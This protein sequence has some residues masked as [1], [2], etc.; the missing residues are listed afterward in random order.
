MSSYVHVFLRVDTDTFIQ[1]ACDSRSS[2]LYYYLSGY[3]P[4]GQIMY[5]SAEHIASVKE[6]IEEDL[7]DYYKDID[8]YQARIKDIGTWA[9]SVEDKLEAVH[10]LSIRTLELEQE[11]DE[12]KA[13]QIRLSVFEDMIDLDYYDEDAPMRQ[14]WIGIECGSVVSVNDITETL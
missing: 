6:K 4:Y 9:N 3:A 14:L 5:F 2:K 7:S 12:I 10:D 1:I 8:C 11:I 13:L